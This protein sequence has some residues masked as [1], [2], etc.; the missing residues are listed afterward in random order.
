VFLNVIKAAEYV[1]VTAPK[2]M[3][4]LEFD[5]AVAC[6]WVEGEAGPIEQATI[7]ERAWSTGDY[8]RLAN[9]AV[10]ITT[11]DGV[12]VDGLVVVTGGASGP[13]TSGW[14]EVVYEVGASTPPVWAV[15]AALAKTKAIW[16]GRLGPKGSDSARDASDRAEALIQ[17]HR[18]GARP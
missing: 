13:L 12:A 16:Q 5:V 1:G 6:D 7:T 11:V 4:A 14:H 18:K 15:A 9:P 10:S 2:D 8:L 17:L 3:A